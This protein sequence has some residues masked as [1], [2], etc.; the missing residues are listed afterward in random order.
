MYEIDGLKHGTG[1][2]GG[3]N[4]LER[5][6]Q[7]AVL[8]EDEVKIAKTE[9]L[10]SLLRI[11]LGTGQEDVLKRLPVDGNIP[12][13]TAAAKPEQ[14]RFQR[15]VRIFEIGTELRQLGQLVEILIER[16]VI[17]VA[18]IGPVIRLPCPIGKFDDARARLIR[19]AVQEVVHR[20]G[21]L[22]HDI[23]VNFPLDTIA[24]SH[25]RIGATGIRLELLLR[26]GSEDLYK[27]LGRYIIIGNIG[28]FLNQLKKDIPLVLGEKLFGTFHRARQQPVGSVEHL[29]FGESLRVGC[30][31]LKK[32]LMNIIFRGICHAMSSLYY[33]CKDI[34]ISLFPCQFE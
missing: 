8:G 15:L 27:E 4:V 31:Y 2:T 29:R 10:R 30:H 25:E 7:I 33:S 16:E 13:D 6:L 17:K 14:P 28:V 12:H 26:H 18:R 11:H 20:L 23:V 19:I 1:R 32:R 9:I 3:G 34:K 22:A 24:I 5:F 21:K